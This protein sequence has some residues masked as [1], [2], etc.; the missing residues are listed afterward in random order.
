MYTYGLERIFEKI[1][2]S[3]LQYVPDVSCGPDARI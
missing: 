1:G 3:R 2:S